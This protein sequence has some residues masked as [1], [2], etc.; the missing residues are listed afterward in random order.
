M[1]IAESAP[2]AAETAKLHKRALGVPDARLK[3][4][5]PGV[6]AGIGEGG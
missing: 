5:E 1:S 3:A 4:T 2:L 6:H